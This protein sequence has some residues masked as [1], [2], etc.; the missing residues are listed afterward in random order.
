MAKSL[1]CQHVKASPW[2]VHCSVLVDRE[3]LPARERQPVAR[4]LLRTGVIST[5]QPIITP[6][7]S[8]VCWMGIAKEPAAVVTVFSGS[9]A[10]LSFSLFS[11]V[12]H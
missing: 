8:V 7:S 2:H 9:V 11:R 6:R 3:G 1:G 5:Q 10:S 12:K 4:A